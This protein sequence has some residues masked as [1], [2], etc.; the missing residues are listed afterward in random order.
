MSLGRPPLKDSV[1]LN[2]VRFVNQHGVEKAAS[3]LDLSIA[4]IRNHVRKAFERGLTK[5][6]K[7]KSGKPAEIKEVMT[8][9]KVNP[10]ELSIIKQLRETGTLPN[11]SVL[12]SDASIQKMSS[13]N[14]DVKKRLK[15]TMDELEET[16]KE[17]DVLTELDAYKPKNYSYSVKARSKDSESTAVMVASDWHVEEDVD[18]QVVNGLN[19]YNPLIAK[20]RARKFFENGLKLIEIQRNG[21][22][23]DELILAVLGDMITGYI[24]DELMEN[25]HL[26]PAEATELAY[27][28]LHSGIEFLLKEGGFKKITVVCAPGNHGRMTDKTHVSSRH[29][30][31]LEWL[32]YS[33]LAKMYK[34]HSIVT[35]VIER[36]Y[37]SYIS[38]Y[39]NFVVRF[40]HGDSLKFG[41]G[42]GGITIPTKKAIAQWN[43]SQPRKVNL[44]VFGHFH[45][46]MDGGDFVCNGSLI[47]W[48]AYAIEI[49]AEFE[50]PKQAFFLIE[51]E[52]GKTI[53]APIRVE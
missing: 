22:K 41:G 47:G 21:T 20:E 24:H 42:V 17:L 13:E 45:Q 46:F 2:T 50:K 43:K 37:H 34:N 36:G 40:H 19:E 14:S 49:K 26:A 32:L 18:P 10:N 27:D 15:I 25:N 7:S 30:N 52:M 53:V 4:Q 11:T 38:L 9:L 6:G 31:S 28:L 44:D 12:K 33:L 29:G 48:N 8:D 5:G 39:D 3:L 51:K 1:V 23:I 16:R 35:F